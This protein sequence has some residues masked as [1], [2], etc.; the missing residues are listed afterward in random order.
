MKIA[1]VQKVNI[2]PSDMWAV[3]I[4]SYDVYYIDQPG[5]ALPDEG[6]IL[7]SGES[8]EVRSN[9]HLI[10]FAKKYT[11]TN[12]DGVIEERPKRWSFFKKIFGEGRRVIPNPYIA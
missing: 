11:I 5:V 8:T 3:P 12:N 10:F 9:H 7:R 6:V 4:Y 1:V 2:Q